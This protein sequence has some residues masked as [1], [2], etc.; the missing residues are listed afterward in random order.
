MGSTLHGLKGLAD[1]M[2]PRLSQHLNGHVLRNHVTLYQCPDE[3]V[4]RVRGGREPHF[5]LLEADLHQ[6]LKKLQLIFQRHRVDQR[7][8]AVP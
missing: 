7:L 6:K 4:L 1:N 2:L 5:D 8:I 3:I